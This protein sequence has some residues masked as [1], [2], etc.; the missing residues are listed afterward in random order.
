MITVY[1]IA[2]LFPFLLSALIF[3]PVLILDLVHENLFHFS[4]SPNSK[5]LYT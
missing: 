5:V 1:F 2:V 4:I 3:I